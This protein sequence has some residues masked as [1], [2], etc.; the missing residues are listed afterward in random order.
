MSDPGRPAALLV[1]STS[2]LCEPA[3]E[4]LGGTGWP[5]ERR[6]KLQDLEFRSRVWGRVQVGV[7][8]GIGQIY[9]NRVGAEVGV[10]VGKGLGF[11]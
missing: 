2:V 10:R 9:R 4:E 8:V 5:F 7:R 11:G 6:L 1:P 3:C